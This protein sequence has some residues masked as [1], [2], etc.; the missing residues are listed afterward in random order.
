[1]NLGI[2]TVCPT[3]AGAPHP[4]IKRPVDIGNNLAWLQKKTHTSS[5]PATVRLYG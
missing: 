2:L 4:T 1:M 5:A 3:H